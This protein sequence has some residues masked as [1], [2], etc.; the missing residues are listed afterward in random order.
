MVIAFVLI[1]TEP[2]REQEIYQALVDVDEIKD[3]H[4]LFGEYDLILKVESDSIDSISQVITDK[5]RKLDG[6]N[7]TKTLTGAKI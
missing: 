1:T 2:G 5:I 6:I 7:D 3:L 4:A